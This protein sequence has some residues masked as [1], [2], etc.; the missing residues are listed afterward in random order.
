MGKYFPISSYIGKPFLI[1]DFATASL[2]ISLYMG[3][4]VI[5]FFISVHNV[6]TVGKLSEQGIMAQRAKMFSDKCT[7]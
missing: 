5:F 7:W 1:Y 3:K 6:Y 4:K 2:R